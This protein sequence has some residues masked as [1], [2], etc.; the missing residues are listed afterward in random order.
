MITLFTAPKPFTGAIGRIQRNAVWSWLA[1]GPEVE[2]LLVGEEEGMARAA[3]ELGVRIVPNIERNEHGTPLVNSI[4]RRAEGEA[5]HDLLCYLNADII[6]LADFLPTVREVRRRFNR[7]LIVGQRLDVEIEEQWALTDF[8]NEAKVEH[9]VSR[10]RPHPPSGSDYFVYPRG[11]FSR[12]PAF[13]LGRSGWDNWMIFAGRSGGLPVVDAS[14][15]ITILHQ[16]H[17][18][19][20]LPG[21]QS[22][23][24]LPESQHNVVLAGGR[25]TMFTLADANWTLTADGVR[26]KGWS[27]GSPGRRIEAWLYA[28]LG[29]GRVGRVARL[30]LHPLETL[31]YLHSKLG[32]SEGEVTDRRK[33]TGGGPTEDLEIE[34]M[35]ESGTPNRSDPREI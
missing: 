8:E 17:D 13:A 16:D 23:Y 5:E 29:S 20:H 27:D 4:F 7:F 31:R 19:R 10:A 28:R 6:L 26:R 35:V 15:S 32:S 30:V 12:M 11:Q 25:Q 14:R 9:L 2:V 1:L 22:H 34:R 24:R 18:Y 33:P 3:A 21:G